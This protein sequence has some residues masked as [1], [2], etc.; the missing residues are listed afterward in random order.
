MW[1]VYLL[2][3][4]SFL[5]S[6]FFFSSLTFSPILQPWGC[7]SSWSWSKQAITGILNVSLKLSYP[8][9]FIGCHQRYLTALTSVIGVILFITVNTPALCAYFR[10]KK[11]R[12]ATFKYNSVVRKISCHK[13]VFPK[14]MIRIFF[15]WPA[16]LW[17]PS[18][19]SLY[20]P[21]GT[22]SSIRQPV[23]V[24]FNRNRI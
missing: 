18:S 9:G 21:T 24:I 6:R 5:I 4:F 7:L 14:Q 3:N 2:R 15:R 17:Q 8:G 22:T 10:T 12:H 11:S 1:L 23:S 20:V 16:P 19:F 13:Q